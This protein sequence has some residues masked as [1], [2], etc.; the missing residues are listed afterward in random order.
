MSY[1][2]LLKKSAEK[3]FKS[4]QGNIQLKIT[5]ALIGL[6]TNPFPTKVK[7][8]QNFEGYRIRVGDYRILYTIN[9]V[10]K[11]IEIFSIGHRKE[12]YKNL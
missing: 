5:D 6:E 2:V 11:I 9:S 8:L 7:K 1:S 10:K 3:E 12:V 4:L